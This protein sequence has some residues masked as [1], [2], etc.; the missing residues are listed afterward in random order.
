[1]AIA[2]AI[3]NN[4]H[5]SST[6]EKT[7]ISGCLVCW[8]MWWSFRNPTKL[9]TNFLYQDPLFGT[10]VLMYIYICSCVPALMDIHILNLFVFSCVTTPES[11][12][13][14]WTLQ[15]A[16]R[17][18][19]RWLCIVLHNDSHSK[20]SNCASWMKLC[21]VM[22]HIQALVIVFHGWNYWFHLHKLIFKL[23]ISMSFKWE[24][25]LIALHLLIQQIVMK[26]RVK[27]ERFLCLHPW[28]RNGKDE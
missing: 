20:I 28:D 15:T 22:I 1:M 3:T 19:W 11:K 14:R 17:F 23:W 5:W 16:K 21:Y 24:D 7:C 6:K 12:F 10:C 25:V 18:L 9:L 13:P 2:K 4:N 8:E 27:N 26:N